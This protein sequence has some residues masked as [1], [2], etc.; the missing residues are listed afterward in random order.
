M[1]TT[2]MTTR[3]NKMFIFIGNS[4]YCNY[5][6][7]DVLITTSLAL[8]NIFFSFSFNQYEKQLY[9]SLFIKK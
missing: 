9:T 6:I 2:M 8:I 5:T 4:Q 7:N 3:F 1:L